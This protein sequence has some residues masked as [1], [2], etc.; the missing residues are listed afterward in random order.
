MI[1]KTTTANRGCCRMSGKGCNRCGN[2]KQSSYDWLSDI[3]IPEVMRGYPAVE[4]QF[5]NTRKSYFINP[6]QLELSKG[7]FVVVEAAVGYDLGEVTLTGP[8]VEFAMKKHRFRPEKGEMLTVLRLA[9]DCDHEQARIA[10]AKEEQTM[11]QARQISADLGLDMKIGDVEYQGDGNKAIFYYI[12]DG[13]VDFRQLIRV[14][15]DTFRIRIE[16]RQIGARQEAGRIGGIG[17]CGRELCCSS[18]MSTFVSVNTS[19]ARVQDLSPNPQKLT[20]QCGKLKCCMNYEVNAYAEAQKALPRRDVKL[21]T[22]EALYHFFKADVLQKMITYSTAE[23]Y[24]EG[25]ITI[26]VQRAFEIIM[27]NKQGQKPDSIMFN[28]DKE[29]PKSKPLDIL[30]DNSLTRFDKKKGEGGRSNQRRRSKPRDQQQGGRGTS[31]QRLPRPSQ[32]QGKGAAS[33]KSRD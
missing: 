25:L 10:K 26:S 27:L 19:A 14:L 32:G 3:P 6:H 22:K 17:S 12:A 5:K 20:G 2:S 13:R 21:E 11:I 31:P 15:A 9:T 28:S 16:M 4:V 1:Y 33:S 30:S 29:K 23:R 18:W 24:P 7:D 8:L